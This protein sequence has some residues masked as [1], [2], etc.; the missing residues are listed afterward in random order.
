MFVI[1]DD[2]A[3]STQ[4]LP[5][6]AGKG[7]MDGS[8]PVF[9]NF[10]GTAAVATTTKGRPCLCGGKRFTSKCYV[11][12]NETREWTEIASL[13]TGRKNAFTIQI[14]ENDFIVMGRP[15]I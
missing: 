9:P 11:F 15:K 13:Q 12:N 7:C 5:N 8:L 6:S 2:G 1:G 3:I 4:P 10:D 14:N